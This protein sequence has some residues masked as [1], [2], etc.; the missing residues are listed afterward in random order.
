MVE[1]DEETMRNKKV[2]EYLFTGGS[3]RSSLKLYFLISNF[4][5]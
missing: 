1:E 5:S 2:F 3:G 4:L